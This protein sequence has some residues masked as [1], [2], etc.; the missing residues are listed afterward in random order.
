MIRVERS[1]VLLVEHSHFA[2]V[3]A[4]GPHS[5]LLRYKRLFTMIVSSGC[6]FGH[7]NFL[8]H[9]HEFLSTTLPGS[10][11][12]LLGL[13]LRPQVRDVHCSHTDLGVLPI[14]RLFQ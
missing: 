2:F 14:C 13:G 1:C 6:S 5:P 7:H 9:K 10:R 4:D 12:C 3:N 11:F 8:D